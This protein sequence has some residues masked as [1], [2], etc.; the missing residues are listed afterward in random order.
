[1]NKLLAAAQVLLCIIC[2]NP[3]GHAQNVG[4]P[5]V[6]TPQVASFPRYDNI[7]GVKPTPGANTQV[8]MGGTASSVI[9]SQNQFLRQPGN[10]NQQQQLENI[11]K[12]VEDLDKGNAQREYLQATKS[13]GMPTVSYCN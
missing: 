2:C 5:T 13:T 10:Q 3:K 1:M 4:I 7:G 12:D 9:N 11:R 6:P 8:Q